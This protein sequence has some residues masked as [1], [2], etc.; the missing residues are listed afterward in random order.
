MDRRDTP[1][2][3]HALV[4]HFR[5]SLWQQAIV[6]AAVLLSSCMRLCTAAAVSWHVT[7]VASGILLIFICIYT[8]VY[9]YAHIYIWTTCIIWYLSGVWCLDFSRYYFW[10]TYHTEYYSYLLHLKLDSLAERSAARARQY[11]WLLHLLVREPNP[12]MI[13]ICVWYWSTACP[14]PYTLTCLL[15][16]VEQQQHTHLSIIMY[17][18]LKTLFVSSTNV[19]MVI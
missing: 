17:V 9:V 15:P 10:A 18:C 3:E 5:A 8:A 4:L 2:S 6:T 14:T 19:C 12:G 11:Y 13:I 1:S 7:A 16:G